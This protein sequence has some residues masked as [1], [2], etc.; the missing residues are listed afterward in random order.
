[1]DF[2]INLTDIAQFVFYMRFI[3]FSPLNELY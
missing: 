3:V 1:M 2:S